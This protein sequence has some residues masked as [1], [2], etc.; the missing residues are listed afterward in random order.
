LRA[1]E[2]AQNAEL[3]I[4]NLDAPAGLGVAQG[5]ARITTASA[6]QPGEH[7]FCYLRYLGSDE[8]HWR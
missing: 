5:D 2:V 8:A 3:V 7:E 4:V 1:A 6:V